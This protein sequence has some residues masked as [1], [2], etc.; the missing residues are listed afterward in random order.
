[1]HNDINAYMNNEIT[2]EH[3]TEEVHINDMVS[4]DRE[5]ERE[6]LGLI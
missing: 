5:F 2:T 1:M 6:V 4:V 3:G